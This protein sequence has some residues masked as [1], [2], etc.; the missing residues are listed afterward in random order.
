[1][2]LSFIIRTYF[3]RVDQHVQADQQLQQPDNDVN[4]FRVED[5]NLEVRYIYIYKER[6]SAR[7]RERETEREII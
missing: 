5:E 3:Q 4:R 2:S 6:E 1:M 7:K